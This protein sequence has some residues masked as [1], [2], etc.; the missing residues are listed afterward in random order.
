MPARKPA[1]VLCNRTACRAPGA[2][3]WNTSTRAYYC[4]PCAHRINEGAPGLCVKGGCSEEWSNLHSHDGGCIVDGIG[5]IKQEMAAAR[6]V[7]TGKQLA[8][9]AMAGVIA[10]Q[11][12]AIESV[13]IN[14]ARIVSELDSATHLH[15]SIGEPQVAK[16]IRAAWTIAQMTLAQLAP[17]VAKKL[18]TTNG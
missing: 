11:K 1:P 3:W 12:D 4:T 7:I 13:R 6:V 9:D 14:L 18:E 2:I 15:N 10:E 5:G 8:V 16:H 17:P